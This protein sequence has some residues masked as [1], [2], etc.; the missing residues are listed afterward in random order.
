MGLENAALKPG[1]IVQGQ[2]PQ[3]RPRSFQLRAWDDLTE[4]FLGHRR[5]NAINRRVQAPKSSF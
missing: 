2:S 1:G 4:A 5:S 3:R